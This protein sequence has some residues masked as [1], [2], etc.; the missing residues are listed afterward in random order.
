MHKSRVKIISISQSSGLKLVN[1]NLKLLAGPTFE[2]Q[3][4]QS[5]SPVHNQ[6]EE[7]F[8]AR[9]HGLPKHQFME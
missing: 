5:E 2:F 7:L 9:I 1:D 3:A 6:L 8:S 4:R